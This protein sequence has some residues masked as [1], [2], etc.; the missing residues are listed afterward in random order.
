[1]KLNFDAIRELLLVIEDQPRN[2]DVNKVISDKRL[3]Y[4]D[5]DEL[6]YALEKM[7]ESRL[8]IGKVDKSKLGHQ[9]DVDSIS[10]EGHHF[11]DSVR[12]EG[13]WSKVKEIAKEKG[14]ATLTSLIPLAIEF[15]MQ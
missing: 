15:F 14:V 13:S 12:N 10:L 7:I 6:G 3:E 11:L 1:M 8:L 9:I 4:F 2:V 5:L